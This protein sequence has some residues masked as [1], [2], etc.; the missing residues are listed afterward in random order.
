M[1]LNDAVGDVHSLWASLG[2]AIE[3]HYVKL[4]NIKTYEQANKLVFGT[5]YSF[6]PVPM[7]LAIRAE[8]SSAPEE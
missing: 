1:T 2:G 4:P 8:R 5:G 3:S 6:E 7:V